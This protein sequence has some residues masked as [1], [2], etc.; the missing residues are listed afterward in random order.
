MFKTEFFFINFV[1]SISHDKFISQEISLF[2]PLDILLSFGI[3]GFHLLSYL[4][5]VKTVTRYPNEMI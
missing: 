2:N 3:R 4:D 5:L 1:F